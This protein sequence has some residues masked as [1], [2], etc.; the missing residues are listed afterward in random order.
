MLEDPPLL[1]I[2]RRIVR[3]DPALLSRFAKANSCW[4][5]DAQDGRGGLD[6]AIKP[7][8]AG[9]P[10]GA[11]RIC[12]PALTCQC[13]PDDNLALFAAVSVAEPGD[14]IVAASEGFTGSAVVGDLLA[15]MARNKG[16]AAIVVDG[17]VRDIAGLRAF[18]LPIFARGLTPN[19]GVRNGPGTVGF[20]VHAGGRRVASGDL[21]VADEDGVATVP[22]ADLE[23]V[24]DRIDAIEKAESAMLARVEA[25]LVLP[26]AIEELLA[27]DR[28]RYRD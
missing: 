22:A 28:V 23:A 27:S 24:A 2:D 8:L 3:P 14:V 1:T 18:A 12:G 13:G 5:G 20:P 10:A 11:A 6:A 25:G 17:M 19:S 9:T 21:V 7:V 16:V 15:G 26:E 4:I